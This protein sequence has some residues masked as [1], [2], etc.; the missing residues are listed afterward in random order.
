MSDGDGGHESGS[1]WGEITGCSTG[2][3]MGSVDGEAGSVDVSAALWAASFSADRLPA[4]P[5]PLVVRQPVVD[6]RRSSS[7]TRRYRRSRPDA[8]R[9][10]DPHRAARGGAARWPG[11]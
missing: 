11:G 2:E 7:G 9:R 1:F 6:L 4:F 10:P 3:M 8:A 5:E